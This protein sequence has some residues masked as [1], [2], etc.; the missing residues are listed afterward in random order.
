MKIIFTQHA[1]LRCVQRKLPQRWVAAILEKISINPGDNEH[2]VDGTNLKVFFHD[3]NDI[4]TVITL[5]SMVSDTKPPTKK[6]VDL[7][8][9]KDM[10][11]KV[12]QKHAR[13]S[14]KSRKKF[15][16]K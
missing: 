5:Y 4:R 9:I 12:K 6:Y 16:K 14:K 10:L 15:K 2:V 13:R 1:K 7:K 3:E 11:D 8:P